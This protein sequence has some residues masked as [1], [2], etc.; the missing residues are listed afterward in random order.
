MAGRWY[1]GAALVAAV[2][3]V[4]P[5]PAWSQAG[6][7]GN[8]PARPQ[9]APAPA[10]APVAPRA[11]VAP[12]VAVA[13]P[14]P[15]PVAPPPAVAAA[16]RLAVPPAGPFAVEAGAT[17]FTVRNL[18]GT[19]GETTFVA[20]RVE[21]AGTTL[22]AADIARL[23]DPAS[24]APVAERLGRFAASSVVI[25]ELYTTTRGPAGSQ[26]ALHRDLR[27][28][29]IAGGKLGSAIG[30]GA[31]LEQVTGGIRQDGRYGR[32]EL[33][34]LDF[35][36][37]AS[38][39]NDPA[40]AGPA[41]AL[42]PIY[43]SATLEGLSLGDGRGGTV[44]VSRL[45]ARDVSG[46]RTRDGWA[47]TIARSSAVPADPAQRT[48]AEKAAS[49]QA[50]I[51]LASA[52]EIGGLE[53]TGITG[54][55]A[56]LADPS[57]KIA[58]LAY[59]GGPGIAPEIG[60]DGLEAGQAGNGVTVASMTATGIALLPMLQTLK[61]IGAAPADEFSPA[62]FRRLVP[63]NASLRVTGVGIRSDVG[64]RAQQIGLGSFEFGVGRPIEGLPSDIQ[65]A[66]R[67]VSVPLDP[68]DPTAQPAVRLGYDR[69]EG[70][71]AASLGYSEPN[72]TVALRDFSV[73]AAGMGSVA[74][75]AVLG[76]VSREIFSPDQALATVA[77]V[78]ATVRSLDVTIENGGLFEKVVAR[79]A[80]DT[81]KSP[82]D[83][84]RDYGL[85]AAIGIPVMLGNSAAAKEL[86]QAVARFVA[87]PGRLA[88]QA[89][90]R[91]PA[92]LGFTDFAAAADPT[93]LLD[94]IDIT[95]TAE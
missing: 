81:G 34:D 66:V 72:S 28:S 64:G 60:L 10:P 8:A 19:L 36:Y 27:L 30:G 25:P 4:A 59:R 86:G 37:V 49:L 14:P 61:D 12:P 2:L 26:T 55:G 89:R 76:N 91:D 17:G 85:A 3:S 22:A 51:D 1:S 63:A 47:A 65:I 45:A 48:E 44:G 73:R 90:P 93:A 31:I 70:S 39:V 13:P 9:P 33:R 75:R 20:P 57:V 29:D 80:A 95:A 42:Q 78:G 24:G 46:R 41:P 35:G 5:G 74:I 92:G 84:R 16:P 23:L 82:S 18:A 58:R 7:F 15:A 32:L 21:I 52:Y 6:G 43:A 87:K 56:T 67:D 77:A 54:T 69:I 83:V 94:K 88:I 53:A 11:P 50:L 79:Q 40:P 71:L 38:L 68:Q 62:Q